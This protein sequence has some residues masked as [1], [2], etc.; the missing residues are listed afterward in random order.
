MTSGFPAQ[1]IPANTHT[2]LTLPTEEYDSANLHDTST[3]TSRLT[4]QVAGI[5]RISAVVTWS[6]D[7]NGERALRVLKNG[8]TQNSVNEW[9]PVD[10]QD[11]STEFKLAVGDYVE[12][13]VQQNSGTDLLAFTQSLSM[14][15]VAP[16]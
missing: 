10:D 3:N 2:I 9:A 4:A 12:L 16:G 6:L 11:L 13:G 8:V 7:S 15:W 1:T 14:S 5:Y